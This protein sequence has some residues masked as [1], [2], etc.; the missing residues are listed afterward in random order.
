MDDVFMKMVKDNISLD[1]C[2]SVDRHSF[3]LNMA[4]TTLHHTH[5]HQAQIEAYPEAV[6][7]L[8]CWMF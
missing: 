1:I 2:V 6:S 4:E 8:T 5:L 3:L 7:P